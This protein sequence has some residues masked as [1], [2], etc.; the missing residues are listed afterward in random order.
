MITVIRRATMG[1]YL[2]FFREVIPGWV[3]YHGGERVGMA[4][5][6]YNKLN[7]RWWAYLNINGDLDRAGGLR[8]VR[9]MR[10]GLSNLAEDVYVLCDE[11]NHPSAP[12]LL[13]ALGFEPTDE[14]EDNWPVWKKAATTEGD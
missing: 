1:D 7:D 5:I 12:R 8:L 13:S 3:I 10:A 6:T 11:G 9:E 2:A 14:V 4:G